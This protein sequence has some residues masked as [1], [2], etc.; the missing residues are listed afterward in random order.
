VKGKLLLARLGKSECQN[1]VLKMV[2]L[3]F[4][5]SL[6]IFFVRETGSSFIYEVSLFQGN[7]CLFL[8]NNSDA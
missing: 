4:E 1:W 6:G 5:F 3:I 2:L 8:V 7:V